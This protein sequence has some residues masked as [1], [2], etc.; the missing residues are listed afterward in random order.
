[1]PTNFWARN[2]GSTLALLSRSPLTP[3]PYAYLTFI[4]DS[5]S[6]FCPHYLTH[7]IPTRSPLPSSLTTNF[8]LAPLLPIPARP[9]LGW[10][11]CRSSLRSRLPAR[12]PRKG[13]SQATDH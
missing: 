2:P 3:T 13:R 10:L 5:N 4:T 6:H 12:A 7:T 9:L 11:H 1:M 8:M